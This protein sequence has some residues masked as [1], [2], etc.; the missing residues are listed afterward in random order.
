[1]R[2][3]M[4]SP[5]TIPLSMIGLLHV[6]VLSSLSLPTLT[7]QRI[8]WFGLG[9]RLLELRFGFAADEGSMEGLGETEVIQ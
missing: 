4:L 3:L 2:M 5:L 7:D 6:V 9:Q 1:M 8:P